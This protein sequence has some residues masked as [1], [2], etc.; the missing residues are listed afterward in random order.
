V[1][2]E[3]TFRTY[4]DDGIRLWID[5]Q[6]LIDNWTGHSMA[7]DSGSIFLVS[8]EM[9]PLKIEYYNGLY[10]GSLKV[11][12][13]VPDGEET[14]LDTRNASL[15]GSGEKGL[16]AQYYDG[17]DL[18]DFIHSDTASSINFSIAELSIHNK[19]YS[20]LQSDFVVQLPGGTYTLNWHDPQTG[21]LI[22]VR[23]FEHAGGPM[24]LQTPRF[25]MDILFEILKQDS[26][27]YK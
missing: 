15:P 2:G 4:S 20:R 27:S 11:T 12:W 21:R 10:G 1:S 26:R 17:T 13:R 25:D 18:D 7:V 3:Y 5:K 9:V 16:F 6:L 8:G 14:I 19:R 23:E 22:S 24:E